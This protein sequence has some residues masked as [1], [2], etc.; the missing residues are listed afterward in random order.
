MLDYDLTEIA[1]AAVAAIDALWP[2]N[3]AVVIAFNPS[4]APE[5]HALYSNAAAASLLP[6]LKAMVA[7]LEAGD[8]C[9]PVDGG[10]RWVGGGRGAN[11]G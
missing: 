4:D 7:R 1:E 11:P 6:V 3:K 10:L 8:L 9:M 2:V 5:D